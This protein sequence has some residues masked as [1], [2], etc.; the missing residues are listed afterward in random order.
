MGAMIGR[1]SGFNRIGDYAARANDN[2]C[3]LVQ[4]ETRMAMANL[5]EIVAVDGVDGVFIG[6]A[7]LAADMGG[8][9]DSEEVQRAIEAGLGTIIKAG[10]PAGIMTF[11]TALNKRYIELGAKFVAV[12]ADVT[13]YSAAL[14]NLAASYGLGSARQSTK[15]EK[16]I[17]R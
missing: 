12:G 11:S 9:V 8:P 16:K 14:D 3:L 6:P 4:V 10:K 13:E 15:A 5:A 2:V 7:D 17:N 1:A